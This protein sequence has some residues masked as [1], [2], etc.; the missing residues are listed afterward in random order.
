MLLAKTNSVCHWPGA[1]QASISTNTPPPRPH[2]NIPTACNQD[3]SEL[4]DVRRSFTQGPI[5]PVDLWSASFGQSILLA[6]KPS[7]RLF[8]ALA[9][10]VF[11][12]TACASHP[13]RQG[14]AP[15]ASTEPIADHPRY[16]LTVR[17]LS[18][19]GEIYLGVTV[20]VKAEEPFSAR[21]TDGFGRL[22][23]LSGRL[24][25][26]D[27]RN[28]RLEGLSFAADS[29]AKGSSPREAFDV[30]ANLDLRLDEM[31][32]AGAIH[33]PRYEIILRETP[34]Y[35]QPDGAANGSQPI[36]VE[37]NR[38]SSAAGSRR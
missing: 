23:D 34:L 2:P 24:H 3:L 20:P 30:K 37:T 17:F 18:R 1:N 33:G 19:L 29:P 12:L 5:L 36:R 35:G 11:L 7:P 8:V 9:V 13:L 38:T 6:M 25:T 22:I 26:S 27:G 28:F 15:G 4:P 10:G 31:H 14:E 21:C 32:V 16:E